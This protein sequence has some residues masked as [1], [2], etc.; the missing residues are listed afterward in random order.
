MLSIEILWRVRCLHKIVHMSIYLGTVCFLCAT[1]LRP[2][3][4]I[5]VCTWGEKCAHRIY[6]LNP[7]TRTVMSIFCSRSKNVSNG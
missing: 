5:A 4:A 3:E 1:Y 7:S 2:D 6:C